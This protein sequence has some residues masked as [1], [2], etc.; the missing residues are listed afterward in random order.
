MIERKLQLNGLTTL[1]TGGTPLRYY[2]PQNEA[3]LRDILAECRRRGVAWR[4]LGGGSNLLVE[5]GAL[6]FAVI[7]LHAPGFDRI[8][9][10]GSCGVQVGA[11]LPTARLLS[12]C[13]RQ[14]LGGIEFLAGLP[15]TIGG[16]A[17]GN[18]G[19][20]G[21][22]VSDALRR[23][24]LVR[25]DGSA[26][27]VP[28]ADLRCSY[29]HSAVGDAV[30]TEL[31]FELEPREP[32]LVRATMRRYVR[33]RAAR[34]PVGERSAGCVFRNPDGTSA[35]RLL[36]LCGLKGVRVGRAEVSAV[37]A[38]FIV[39]RGGAAAADVLELIRVMKERV[40]GRF[41]VDLELEVRHWPGGARVA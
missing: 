18:A 14:G 5:D 2:H 40:R 10:R 23:V 17:A 11:G 13:R 37:H 36:D 3:E 30:I 25:E 28:A 32:E 8:E 9:R 19:A 7:H 1:Q 29:R 31:E 22:T 35:G 12:W 33:R 24:R 16:A 15:G 20:W 39:N 27:T 26:V 21:Q 38:N 41:G 34:H 6:P 4:I